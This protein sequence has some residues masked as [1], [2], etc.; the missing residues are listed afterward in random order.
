MLK[1]GDIHY[2][3]EGTVTGSEQRAGRP[4]IIVS[5]DTCNVKSEVVEVVFLT[6]RP[7]SN[8]PTHITIRSAPHMSTAICE[9]IT[10][11]SKERLGDFV[12]A[13]TESE[14][15]QVDVALRYSLALPLPVK[16]LLKPAPTEN[17]ELVDDLRTQLSEALK[18]KD[19][20]KGMYDRL[21]ENILNRR[22]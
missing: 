17:T 19:L 11:V 4:A 9:Q 15:A 6:T 1:R 22:N 13:C 18:E 16:T 20:Y 2:I 3:L 21:I 8:M 5:N 10:S 7:K 12:G 14:M